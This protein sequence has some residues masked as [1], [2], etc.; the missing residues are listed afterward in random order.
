MA[1]AAQPGRD[2]EIRPKQTDEG[3]QPAP[4]KPDPEQTLASPAITPTEATV[5]SGPDATIDSTRLPVGY[6]LDRRFAIQKWLGSGGMG[7]VY[8]AVDLSLKGTRIALK[9]IRPEFSDRVS[10]RERFQQEVLLAQ[11]I[12]H[13]NVCPVYQF[14]TTWGPRGEIWFYTMKLLQGETLAARLRRVGQLPFEEAVRF[15][16][17]IAAGL[18]AAHQAKVIHR[19]VKPGNIFLEKRPT[20]ERAV[21]TDFGL[22]HELTATVTKSAHVVGTPSYMAPEVMRGEAATAQSDV[23][24]FGVVSHE[25]LFGGRPNTALKK[26]LAGRRKRQLCAVIERCMHPNPKQRYASA[27]EAAQALEEAVGPWLTRRKLLVGTAAT[28]ILGGTAWSEREDFYL[29]THPVPRPRRV[30]ILP[31]AGNNLPME[32][33]SLLSGVLETV[34]GVLARAGITERDL[35]VIPPRLL[36]NEK[37][38]TAAAAFGLTGANLVLTVSLRKLQRA[39]RLDLQLLSHTAAKVVREASVACPLNLLYAL[40]VRATEKATRVLDIDSSRVPVQYADSDTTNSEAYAAWERGRDLLHKFDLTSVNSAIAELQ[41]AV[42]LDERFARAYAELAR[43]YVLR[44]HLTKKTGALDVAEMNSAKAIS[45]SPQLGAGY[46]SRARVRAGRGD[47][48]A[49]EADLREALRLEPDDI[50]T[51]MALA[52]LYATRGQTESADRVYE[53]VLKQK[54]DYWPALNDWGNLYFTRADYKRAEKLFS[55]ATEIAPQAALPYRNLSAVYIE[56][57]RYEEAIRAARDSISLLPTGE[58]YDNLGTAFFW[59]GRYRLAASNYENAVRLSPNRDDLWC[60][61][62]DAYEAMG[63][64]AQAASAWRKASQLAAQLLEINPRNKDV[65]A[66]QALFEA[67]LGDKTGAKEALARLNPDTEQNVNRLFSET[68]A[69]ELIGERQTALRLVE[70]CAQMGYSRFEIMHAPEL[71]GLR[72]DSRFRV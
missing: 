55:E 50:D 5:P 34:S 19:D 10:A 66:D 38:Q 25:M 17:E 7:E 47:Y 44:F 37:V 54:P 69:C 56:T 29:A 52:G 68:L 20:G 39:V 18:D 58:A 23:Y 31:A 8:E 60:N 42:S 59:T 33:A 3:S 22:A 28:V 1:A 49:A 35:L 13:P 43:A 30:A 6:V 4:I 14:G 41:K 9:V 45:L 72:R 16:S 65:Q 62:G 21:V 64:K 27:G 46:A 57:E 63:M 11:S 61:L 71:E 36:R 51:Q 24:S 26:D 32:D 15:A 53:D 40:P 48:D 12:S 70:K 2:D 67:K